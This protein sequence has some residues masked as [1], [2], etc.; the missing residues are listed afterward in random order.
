[1]SDRFEIKPTERGLIRLFTVDLP[2][3][4][5]KAF[6]E[7]GREGDDDHPSPLQQALG[8][9]SLDMELVELFP[10]SNLEGVGLPGY[11][12]E[13]LGIA[14]ADVEQDRARLEAIKGPVLIVLSS[15]FGGVAQTL[16]P[17]AP[18]RW[19]GTYAE[20]RAPVAFQPLPSEGAEAAG[21][22]K[23]GPSDAAMSGRIAMVALLVIFA[24]TALV[25]WVAS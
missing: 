21:V 2:Q 14:E 17:K 4:G 5:L 10:V 12:I 11:M 20:E 6:A 1:M 9:Q 3:T 13:G 16:T 7:P 18:L 22:S 23:P 25:I 8:A 15:A 19:V 24:L